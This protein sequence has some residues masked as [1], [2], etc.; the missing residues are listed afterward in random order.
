MS[1]DRISSPPIVECSNDEFFVLSNEGNM[2]LSAMKR[3]IVRQ[4]A[5]DHRG[6]ERKLSLAGIAVGGA[7]LEFVPPVFLVLSSPGEGLKLLHG[8]DFACCSEASVGKDSAGR[9]ILRSEGIVGEFSSDVIFNLT[10]ELI[11]G[12]FEIFPELSRPRGVFCRLVAWKPHGSVLERQSNL[13]NSI[14]FTENEQHEK[15]G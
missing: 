13:H 7:V 14:K 8:P 6:E 12:N 3:V 5:L 11:P 4:N 1:P 9:S 10:G 15:A 2:S